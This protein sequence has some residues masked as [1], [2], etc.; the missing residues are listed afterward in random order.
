VRSLGATTVV[1]YATNDPA[2]DGRRYDMILDAV[3]KLSYPRMR[4][5]MMPTGRFG[6][7]NG[8]VNFASVPLTARS[9]GRRAI[10]AV[11]AF[12]QPNVQYL[13]ELMEA[14]AFHPVIDRTYPLD[15]IVEANRYVESERKTGN[16]VIQVA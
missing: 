13:A 14:D 5:A 8:L 12:T 3:G 9:R 11:P 7:A 10:F 16:V 1:D 2:K 15:Q 4:R 6:A